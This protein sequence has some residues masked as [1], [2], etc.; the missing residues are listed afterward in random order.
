MTFQI[1]MHRLCNQIFPVSF[2]KKKA[3]FLICFS[4]LVISGASAQEQ[5]IADSLTLIYRQNNTADTDK[6]A[7]LYNLSFNEIRDLKKAIQYGEELISLALKTGNKKYLR[8]GYYVLGTK[9]RLLSQTDEA[10]A[11]FFK[12][13]EMAREMNNLSG[14][15]DSYIAIADI[16]SN[17]GNHRTSTNYYNKAVSCLQQTKDSI[18]LASAFLNAGDEFLKAKKYDTAYLYA[19]K[20]KAIFDTLNYPVG[21]AYSLGN[22]GMIYASTG[23]NELAETNLNE[24]I[25]LLEANEDFNAICD[26]LLSI[27]DVYLNKADNSAALNHAKRSLTMAQQYG[28]KQ[29]VIDA[30]LKLSQIYES[31]GNTAAALTFY[32][33]H[34]A[35]RDSVNNLQTVQQM[36]D[37]RT[38]YE[39]S[40][41]Q[42]EVNLLN[43]QKRNQKIIMFSLV[44]ILLLALFIAALL[45]MNNRHRKKAYEVLRLQEQATEEQKLKAEN[46]L[47]E[48][49]SAQKQLIYSAKM[50]SLGEV[51][52]GIAHEIQNP[53]NFVNN[54]S[55]VNIEMLDELKEIMLNKL[56]APDQELV[57]ELINN[58]GENLKKVNVHGKRA[59][60]IVKGMLQ[61]SRGSTGV[62][63]LTDINRLADEALYLSYHGLKAR[64]KAFEVSFRTDFDNSITKIEIVPQ[65]ISRVLLNLCNNAFYSAALKK[66]TADVS[67]EPSVLVTTTKTGNKIKISVK[68]NGDGI[69]Q[70]IID[71]IFQPFY[72]TKPTGEGTGLGLSLSYDI[73]KV[74]EGELKVESEEGRFADFIIELPVGE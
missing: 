44:I 50:V 59:D 39:V 64:N 58:I 51:T 47:L 35:A 5:K 13:A 36:A 1:L 19:I 42:I 24:A 2:F 71:K 69:P 62:K 11:A 48:L 60:A 41:K 23:K 53:L 16:Y 15:G 46:A 56:S 40:Q 63:E 4:C 14:E 6:L 17:A 28:L 18:N 12:S 68:D 3:S 70:Q 61:H 25:I 45:L 74:H 65:D 49:Q 34:I 37:I 55:E 54:F 9:K 8:P 38:N 22:I 67:F 30:D 32:K 43:Q 52:A 31:I 29:Q 73:I 72:T 66:Q 26:Y 7:L 57:D 27:A 33:A 20:A 21:K 10:L